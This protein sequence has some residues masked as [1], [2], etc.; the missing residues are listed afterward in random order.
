[1]NMWPSG[2]PPIDSGRYLCGS[3]AASLPAAPASVAGSGRL[4][5][6]SVV[7]S[8]PA[9]RVSDAELRRQR[10]V[11]SV[12]ELARGD[13]DIIAPTFVHLMPPT[14]DSLTVGQGACLLR[15]AVLVTSLGW[16]PRFR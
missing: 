1:M 12:Q 7:D 13:R 8:A 6:L 14:L 16:R 3:A 4:R 10:A 2:A 5:L 9:P 15:R 11:D